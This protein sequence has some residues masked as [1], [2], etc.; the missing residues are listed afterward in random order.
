V[1]TALAARAEE[2]SLE[3]PG[4]E[5]LRYTLLDGAT[6]HPS[7]KAV[8]LQIVRHLAAGD[9][10]S[11]AL[12]SNRPK[13]RQE[14]LRAYQASVGEEEFKRVFGRFLF[15]ENRIV[16]EVAIGPRRLVI[17]DLGEAGHHLAA[18]YLVEVDGRFVMDE[19]PSAER[20]QLRRVLESYRKNSGSGS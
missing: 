16:A 2:R 11:A 12:L 13:S 7:A 20:L 3:L 9:I 19:V 14:V 10:E 5:T 6:P 1:V 15:P 4:G 17:W 8:S 18:Q